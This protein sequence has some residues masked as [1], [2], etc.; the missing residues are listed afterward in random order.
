VANNGRTHHESLF[1]EESRV[2][3][4]GGEV[5]APEDQP[6]D[7]F[8]GFAGND[9]SLSALHPLWGPILELVRV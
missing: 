3:S 6:W 4:M 2:D 1:E 7:P 8:F 9:T 5:L